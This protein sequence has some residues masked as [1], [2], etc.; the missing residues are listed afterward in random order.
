MSQYLESFLLVAFF[1]MM[2][3]FLAA[4]KIK[5]LIPI[6]DTWYRLS[7][8]S[9]S[10]IIFAVILWRIRE[11]ASS[12]SEFLFG[13][14]LLIRLIILVLSFLGGIIVLLSLLHVDLLVFFGLKPMHEDK[15]ITKGLYRCSRHPMYVGTVLFLI[16]GSIAM[17]NL[18]YLWS[19]V[20]LSVYTLL[21]ALHEE[22]RLEK[23]FPEYKEYRE[24]TVFLIPLSL[25]SIKRCLRRHDF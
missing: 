15:L 21:G 25:K 20:W 24:E 19:A 11:L 10:S 18:I 9:F 6:S 14:P 2:H 3:S 12:S 5:S 23:D 17:L 1:G 13:I 4:S 16:P 7:Y 8:V 22:R